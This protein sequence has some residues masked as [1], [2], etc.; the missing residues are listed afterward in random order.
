MSKKVNPNAR[1]SR[2]AGRVDAEL[3]SK[4]REQVNSTAERGKH[5]RRLDK[6]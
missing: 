2:Q 6:D 5:D 1:D 4:I 3:F